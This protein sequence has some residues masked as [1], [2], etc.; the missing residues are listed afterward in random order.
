[1]INDYLQMIAQPNLNREN[2][3]FNCQLVSPHALLVLQIRL[4][5]SRFRWMSTPAEH[6]A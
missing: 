1:M 6:W 4:P 5:S 3:K 2:Q